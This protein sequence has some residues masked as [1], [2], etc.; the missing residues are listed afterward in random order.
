MQFM[1]RFLKKKL[2]GVSQGT[3]PIRE[4]APQQVLEKNETDAAAGSPACVGEK[5][6]EAK[7]TPASVG[8]EPSAP[9]GLR[10]KWN[11][12]SARIG[13]R[14]RRGE[15]KR[16][17][18]RPP[19]KQ[20]NQLIDGIATAA[21]L[22]LMANKLLQF[23]VNVVFRDLQNNRAL[24]VMLS[25]W[26]VFLCAF[27]C[28]LIRLFTK[29]K[30]HMPFLITF[31]VV[32]TVLLVID[33][34]YKGYLNSLPS[35]AEL[36]KATE[37]TGVQGSVGEV[38]RQ[39]KDLLLRMTLDVIPVLLF[40]IWLRP[41]L[42][43]HLKKRPPAYYSAVHTGGIGAVC[44][45][46]ACMVLVV[47][48]LTPSISAAIL[49]S[50]IVTYHLMDVGKAVANGGQSDYSEEKLSQ[51]VMSQTIGSD[52][53]W[54]VA[55]DKNVVLIQVEALQSFVIGKTYN[56]QEITP[57]LNAFLND[58]CIWFPNHYYQ[59]GGGNTADAE[60]SALNSL[61]APEKE[62]AYEKYPTNTYYGLPW[63]LKDNGYS[64]AYAYHGYIGSFWNRETAYPYQG[65]DDFY[66]LEDMEGLEI[67][68]MMEGVTDL[69][70][71]NR[72]LTDMK[73]Q[74]KDG[75]VMQMA[76]TL[77]THHPYW[78]PEQYLDFEL[79][80][81]DEGTTCGSYLTSMHY[82][83]QCF[84]AYVD[85]LKEAGLWDETVIVLYGD[86]MALPSYERESVEFMEKYFC[87]SYTYA[88]QFR[89]PLLMH[90][91][92]VDSTQITPAN[93][94]ID[95]LP[96]LLHVLGI[97]NTR[98]VMLGHD[99]FV[100]E[101]GFVL[102]QTHLGRGS[103]FTNDVFFQNDQQNLLFLA[104]AVDLQTGE[105]LD[106]AQYFDTTAQEAREIFAQNEYIL[107]NDLVCSLRTDGG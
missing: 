45:A 2:S 20:P 54:G 44:A 23:Y 59:I 36:S 71:F 40:G 56:R 104:S 52:E 39:N 50:E 103:F 74:V 42:N 14:L 67:H 80:P 37:L 11:G 85:G 75:P 92:G 107:Q 61:Y 48:T 5:E 8:T 105:N 91:P 27:V 82:F 26:S 46:C 100:T 4:N 65:F 78:L 53:Y 6:T 87:D 63:I 34:V 41:F 88:E 32:L 101:D 58:D 95:I 7:G 15:K 94:H 49:K 17:R 18:K 22:A 83:D 57:N 3:E 30:N 73:E 33:T 64:G 55:A 68:G 43:K 96:T 21:I 10:E 106:A 66:S 19:R 86:H 12:F 47:W 97:E 76:V 13:K 79:F 89:V 102:E 69:E 25:C 31:H 70:L 60:F 16:E 24:C 99:M 90:V 38:M 35:V 98:G 81:E 93:G 84:G 29:K 1:N 72:M 9:T 28:L 62:A 51:I 77:S